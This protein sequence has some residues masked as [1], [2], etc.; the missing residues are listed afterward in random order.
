MKKT[1][2]AYHW[3]VKAGY[4]M[5]LAIY[6]WAFILICL[7]MWPRHYAPIIWALVALQALV[8]PHLQFWYARNA[9]D[10]V[11][12]EFKNLLIDSLLCGV[13]VA[14]LG[15]PLW[16]TF[17]SLACVT[18]NNAIARGNRG[19]IESS[20]AIAGGIAIGV[21]SAGFN[22]S[23]DTD[24]LVTLMC[25]IGLIVFQ[26]GLANLAFTSNKK[27]SETRKALQEDEKALQES[28]RKLETTLSELREAQIH[29]VQ[30]EK[31][32]ALGSLVAG[33]AHELNTPIG[34]AL[35]MTSS[36]EEAATELERLIDSGKMR[37]S[38]L[39]EYMQ[40]SRE[41][42]EIA[43]RSCQRAAALISSFKQ[44]AADQTSEQRRSFDLRSLVEDN[45]ASLRPSFRDTPWQ[46][47]IDI[48]EGIVCDSY[49]GPLGQVI[50]HLVSNALS[51]AFDGR[52]SGTVRIVAFMAEGRVKL[53]V[54]D[55]GNGMDEATLVRIFEPFY[56]TQR[57]KG[58]PGLGLSIARNM[59][60]GLLGGTIQAASEAGHGSRFSLCFPVSA[61]VG[62]V[63]AVATSQEESAPFRP[64]ID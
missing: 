41:M 63:D 34:N 48:P 59:V 3:L 1:P 36:L 26:T 25:M 15:F 4:R 37:R 62:Q 27:L 54:E 61:R 12:A 29:I 60:T 51:H 39:S 8:C 9:R 18:I 13:M 38:D 50:A 56:T 44:V 33:V 32:A 47:E 31:L 64:G 21:A 11:K 40:R 2:P 5:R 43:S 24:G 23:P 58:G 17:L 30:S 35:T 28:H 52:S 6:A 42:A 14:L 49:P 55:D 46:V 20:L 53:Q 10:S 7:H 19:T 16:I 57:G 45:I 22:F